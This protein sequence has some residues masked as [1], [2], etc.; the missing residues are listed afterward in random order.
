MS[1][2]KKI[3]IDLSCQNITFLEKEEEYKVLNFN[4]NSMNVEV[5]IVDKDGK[6]RVQK[7]AFAHLPKQ[8]KKLIRP[9]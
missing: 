9:L 8:I 7:M 4:Q 5:S 6:K 2:K 3:S 1:K